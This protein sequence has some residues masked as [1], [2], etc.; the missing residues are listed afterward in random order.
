VTAPRAHRPA[1]VQELRQRATAVIG[2]RVRAGRR[3]SAAW[4]GQAA[5]IS[6]GAALAF[7]RE[8]AAAGRL[9]RHPG[10]GGP[11]PFKDTWT[12]TTAAG[13]WPATPTTTPA[14]QDCSRA[15]AAATS[16]PTGSPG[17]VT[18]QATA[19]PAAGCAPSAPAAC[20]SSGTATR[21][22]VFRVLVTGSRSWTDAAAIARALSD[23][24]QVH[25]DR[26]VVVHGA[27]RSGADRI[28]GGWARRHGVQVEAHAADWAAGRGAGPARNAAMVATAPDACL[29]FIRDRSPGATGCADAAERA[30][31]RTRRHTAGTVQQE[32][33]PD[34]TRADQAPATLPLQAAG[35]I[36]QPAQVERHRA[37]CEQAS[38][39][40]PD[41]TDVLFAD[42]DLV[43]V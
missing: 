5:G 12:A 42:L 36:T 11:A 33:A 34:A 32:A 25:G 18:T 9:T 39:Q 27:C 37:P 22:G 20:A 2:D 40:L 35:S 3:L 16:P 4:L 1:G 8:H 43:G 14:E 38:A 28:A 19:A 23:L 15:R 29:A 21:P 6:D 26:L 24:H 7:L 31:I 13:T 17:A 41:V 30:G 10:P